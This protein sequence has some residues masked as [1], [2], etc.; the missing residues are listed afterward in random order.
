MN[1]IYRVVWSASLG[2]YQVASEVA[3][4]HGK[5]SRAVDRRARKAAVAAVAAATAAMSGGVAAQTQVG[6]VTPIDALPQV[7]YLD[8][9]SST[10]GTGW[11]W[12]LVNLHVF[13]TGASSL[14]MSGAFGAINIDPAGTLNGSTEGV[15]IETPAGP[16]L[17][18]VLNNNG[19]VYG[20]TTGVTVSGAL[21]RLSN[22]WVNSSIVGSIGGGASGVQATGTIGT[23]SNA[24][25]ISGGTN[26]INAFFNG[27]ARGTIDSIDNSGLIT[28]G[29]KGIASTG[30]TIGTIT[31]ERNGTT[32][33]TISGGLQGINNVNSGTVLGTISRIQND[34]V[35]TSQ[36]SAIV[37][38]GDMGTIHNSAQ[39]T[40]AGA[41]EYGVANYGSL[42]AI[43]NDGSIS[44]SQA[45][46]V[47][48]G[49]MVTS[50]INTG[51]I[52]SDTQGVLNVVRIGT[53]N[54]SGL[55]TVAGTSGG[56]AG[57][58]SFGTISDLTNSG[59]IAAAAGGNSA[60]VSN[61][62]RID[63]LTNQTGGTIS[64]D[65]GVL[66]QRTSSPT[67]SVG[68]LTNSGEITGV[69]VGVYNAGS[70]ITSLTNTGA[71]GATPAGTIAATG[72]GG[73]A[74]G[75]SNATSTIDGTV[76]NATIGSIA[77]AGVI[78]GAAGGINNSGSINEIHNLA[79]G[80]IDGGGAGFGIVT[81]VPGSNIGTINNDVG[82]T[83]R[84][85]GSAIMVGGGGGSIG[86]INN[87]GTIAGNIVNGGAQDLTIT[88]ATDGTTYGVLQGYAGTGAVGMIQNLLS[89]LRF[90]GGSVLLNDNVRMG[91]YTMYN[92]GA[93]LRL[94]RVVNV[95][96]NYQQDANATLEIRVG[97]GATATGDRTTDS[98]YGRLI[99]DGHVALM[100]GSTI[101]LQ[102][103]GYSFAA[104]QRYVVL[105]T[106]NWAS[107]FNEANLKY[108]IGG[109]PL[110]GSGVKQSNGNYL[111][112][113]VTLISPEEIGRIGGTTGIPQGVPAG[114]TGWSSDGSNVTI[115][116]TTFAT[117]TGAIGTFTNA[118]TLTGTS[119]MGISAIVG[120]V[121][122]F[123]NDGSI[124][125]TGTANSGFFNG[126]AVGTL[127][128]N[129]EI[130]SDSLAGVNNTGTMTSLENGGTVS[131]V[132]NGLANYGSLTSVQNTGT[133]SAP[134]GYGALN[135]GHLGQLTNQGLITGFFGLV[136][137]ATTPVPGTLDLVT[138]NG[139]ISGVQSG[140]ANYGGTITKIDNRAGGSMT[141][142]NA[143]NSFAF[144]IYNVGT[145]VNGSLAVGSIGTISNA[146]AISG[147]YYGIFNDNN[148]G[149]IDNLAGGVI[150]G[151]G[152]AISNQAP[153]AS[154]GAIRNAGTIAGWIINRSQNELSISGATDN[155][156]GT[157]TGYGG[158]TNV[159]TIVS[160]Y[161]DVRLTGG[162]LLVNNDF[163]LR[164]MVNG[165]ITGVRT[166]HNAGS[167]LQVNR[168]LSIF[169]N[170]DQGANATLQIGV[171]GST[172]SNYGSLLVSGNTFIAP[173]STIALQ[174]MG[175]AFAAGQRY[176][177]ID[178]AGTTNYNESQLRYVVN[179]NSTLA[180]SG[181]HQG[182]TLL[183]T[184]FT[185]SVL[186]V[187]N[188]TNNLLSGVGA[189]EASQWS[190]DGTNL[191]VTGTA[192]A[193]I[194]GRLGSITNAGT[195]ASTLVGRS[196][197]AIASN[198]GQVDSV[199]NNGM[200]SA[201]GGTNSGLYVGG[202][203][204]QVVNNGTIMSDNLGGVNNTGA[205]TR[206][207]NN[208]LIQGATLGV[209]NTGSLT[210]LVNNGTIQSM[211][212]SSNSVGL[213]TTAGVGTLTNSGRINGFTGVML[214]ASG[215]PLHPSSFGE[216]RNSGTI[217]GLQ[218]GFANYGGSIGKIDNVAGGVF[219]AGTGTVGALAE[220]LRNSYQIV[221]GTVF[222][223]TIGAI[224]NAGTIKGDYYG[225]YNESSIG[226]I[227]NL[228]GGLITGIGGAI[229]NQA[230][231]SSIAA[232]NN[233]GTIAGWIINRSPNE[234][235]IAGATDGTYGT[236]TGFGGAFP[237]TI[238]STLADTRFTGGRLVLDDHFD[239][240][241]T[242]TVRNDASVLQV[243][244]S[245]N[246]GGNYDQAA[247]GTLQIGV[248][249]N[250]VTTGDMSADSG[251]GRLV[252]AG[253]T[254][255]AAGSRIALQSLGYSFAIGQRYV[256]IDTAGT[257]NYNEGSLKYR[258]N[259]S[260]TLGATGANVVNGTKHD[261]VL[262]VVSDPN[263]GQDDDAGTGGGS[264]GTGGSSGTGTGNGGAG[265]N[266]GGTMPAF[267]PRTNATIASTQNAQSALRGLLGY[268]GVSN[269]QLLNLYN[270]TLGS[271]SDGSTT[272]AN[273]VGQQ[274]AP[275]QTTRA[276]GAATF[277][278]INVVGSHV[279]GLRMASAGGTGVATGDA[280][281]NW[282]VWGQAFG[283]HASQS[284]RDGLDGYGANYG[285]LLIGADRAFGDRW[286]AG[287][288]FQFSR[289]VINN[290]G[291]TSG[292]NTSVNGYG[293]I[294]YA[295][296]TGEP[297]YVNLTGSVVM[298][299]YNSTRLV[300]MQGFNGAANGSFNGQQYVGSAEFGWP[301]ALGRAIV[302][303]LASL[304]YS[305]LTQNS[306][307]ETG[308][309]GTA[310]SV[311]S[312][313]AS[314]VRSALGAKIG[315]PF[316]T[317][318]G[319]WLP[320]L[321]VRWVHEYN[322]TRLSTGA[323]FAA[324]P[325]G[326]TGFTTVGATPVSD[327]ADISLGL[328]LVRAN[329]MSASIRYNLQAGSGF[330]S[331]TG[332]VR[333]QQRF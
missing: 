175:Y 140:L 244:R 182:S 197:L 315:V 18:N 207:E 227:N 124:A 317:S 37:N 186:G 111:D 43:E 258:V 150:S 256:V 59:R 164:T 217:D 70:S 273:R 222:A 84:S 333:I 68:T 77:N 117:V 185:P 297:W 189:V 320:E 272:S 86:V 274:L 107:N 75:I 105:E 29:Q 92:S 234:L 211:F 248:A 306:Y 178:T 166:L 15:V 288:A 99:V 237:G 123:V 179:G 138:N 254:T 33:G 52:S 269:P 90:A 156:F 91:A 97:A 137:Y 148:I 323:S 163:D 313:N 309:N 331:H 224:N 327:L 121:D 319:T 72:T 265:G 22:N 55:I 239:L 87:A 230:A 109:A 261:L 141:A 299:R 180:A 253:N 6:W 76:Y 312:A 58:Q 252:V 279:N 293:L 203:V 304:T 214:T 106:T 302:T 100:S 172:L 147:S 270:A 1:R 169:G 3:S 102:S 151:L 113:I 152:G 62:G 305:Y 268:T 245:L 11:Q 294:G 79:G 154:I 21:S 208:S 300:S 205:L 161:A 118:G 31:N 184:L 215:D 12:D 192:Q 216:I 314:S 25:T 200:I 303:P 228:A 103:M 168:Q 289:T 115:S 158:G 298:Q 210:T 53:I 204:G 74:Y 130:R 96:G 83:I 229:S 285:G 202:V 131:G 231:T 126:G 243:N 190:F 209:A 34:G 183:V 98:G 283:G 139:S 28:G 9:V 295:A 212:T 81:G 213:W 296:Y 194:T 247:G 324:D 101:A 44:G 132:Q 238:V 263:A 60:G 218:Y 14:G 153:A 61:W 110:A 316:E 311:G 10:S 206:L 54:N 135:T 122:R 291:T 27:S 85:G 120:S 2:M 325:T 51:T 171:A 165:T 246:V 271:L 160:T 275:A 326:E 8:D 94:D 93:K 42:G 69:S 196:A 225:V 329:N 159:G 262:T 5:K 191:N 174:S 260:T 266:A 321:S 88:G 108:V 89:N 167:V 146:G 129:G 249:G 286:R 235:K 57:V 221:S 290:D 308:G 50:I 4:S 13:N 187:V 46:I 330:V 259:G 310:L 240:G 195:I 65:Y 127:V 278:S 49:T 104:G 282:G 144:G 173:G 78:S 145:S 199:L 41:L 56:R 35:I 64:G 17:N 257:A 23:I 80:L 30:G 219:S 223:G 284:A 201:T 40:I 7:Y 63:S 48:T 116:G 220:G 170:Y 47:A 32:I 114:G 277:D 267:D 264:G 157:I 226:T 119:A 16:S 281:A 301:L 24:G 142:G 287:G 318:S 73:Y 322:R 36:R 71:V 292:N 82:A 280:A 95:T 134:S 39:G 66:N 233:A 20:S 332:I 193:S 242:R 177:I 128:N 19:Q 155:T 198:G 67:V 250:A 251:Y 125:S 149:L 241:G 232:I 255:L 236:L 276:A 307:T 26:G 45:G 328:T 38:N 176:V 162:N 143:Q 181:A 133:L 188:G 112:L 136:N